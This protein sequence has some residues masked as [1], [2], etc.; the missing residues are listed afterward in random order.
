M[1]KICLLT[2]FIGHLL[3]SVSFF[4][5]VVTGTTSLPRWACVFNTLPLFMLISPLKIAGS[6]NI[7]NG[8]MFLALFFII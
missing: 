3:F 1:L 4:I 2:A 7:A 8:L 5:A 6:G